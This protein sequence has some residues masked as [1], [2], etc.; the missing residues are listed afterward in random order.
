[1]LFV[2]TSVFTRR[3]TR[4]GLEGA[5]RGLQLELLENPTAGDLDPGTG[6]LRKVRMADSSRG[7]GKRGGARV[8]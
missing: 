7:K 5:I 1:L 8:H 4:L 6:G 3:I 2:E